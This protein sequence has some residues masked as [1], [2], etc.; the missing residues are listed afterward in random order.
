M[1]VRASAGDGEY[2]D[3]AMRAPLLKRIA[4][5]TG[6]RFFTPANAAS[7]PE[8]ISY[9]GRGV[10]VVEERELW[11]M[12]VAAHAAARPDRR[13]VGLP[14]RAGAG[15]TRRHRRAAE[16]GERVSAASACSAL[17]VGLVLCCVLCAAPAA[18]RRTPTCSSSP[19][20]PATRSTRRSSTKWATAFIDA[21]KKKDGVARRQHHLSRRAPELDPARIKARS[22]RENVDEGVRRS[23]RARQAERRGRRPAD[24]PRQL[25]RHDGGVQPARART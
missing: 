2:F 1:H 21:A 16:S 15:V 25:R 3:A 23:R 4:E 18:A 22:T 7:L 11:D 5:E 17:I 8:A 9:S 6:G 12:P 19:A 14:A 20:S 13:R 24:R 10:T